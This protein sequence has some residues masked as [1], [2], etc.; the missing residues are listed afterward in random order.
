[1]VVTGCCADGSYDSTIVGQD[2]NLVERNVIHAAD[3]RRSFEVVRAVAPVR[4]QVLGNLRRAIFDGRFQ[5]GERLVE[6]EL[7]DLTGVSRT[8]IREA[9]RHLES[10]GLIENVPNR[11]PVVRRITAEEAV[12]LYQVRAQLEGLAGRLFAQRAT[13]EEVRELRAA[14]SDLEAA[15]ASGDSDTVV[16]GPS[17][18][19]YEVMLRGCR[20]QTA[21]DMLH[22]INNRILLLRATTLRQPGRAPEVTAELRRIVEAIERRDPDATWQA[23]VE[24]VQHA[25]DVAITALSGSRPRAAGRRQP[26]Q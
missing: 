4:Q 19:F 7:C 25:A 22:A 8:S 24:H 1:M 23:C 17:R 12:G 6:R 5:P 11:G 20:N 16:R 9:L 13:Q 15:L 3:E 21:A 26:R 14:L 2:A 18:P 10:E